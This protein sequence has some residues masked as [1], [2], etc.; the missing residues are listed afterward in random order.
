M[1]QSN[2]SKSGHLVNH[3]LRAGILIGQEII[4]TALKQSFHVPFLI[5]VEFRASR[6]TI[7]TTA[8]LALLSGQRLLRVPPTIKDHH[9]GR[10]ANA[11]HR[12]AICLQ[13]ETHRLRTHSR[14]S[15]ALS[16]LSVQFGAPSGCHGNSA[17]HYWCFLGSV[18]HQRVEQDEDKSFS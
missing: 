2:F 4:L 16:R 5:A 3:S 11:K 13:T 14:L 6:D 17:I 10:N 9:A 7:Q 18:P 15:C 1:L 12:L 8:P